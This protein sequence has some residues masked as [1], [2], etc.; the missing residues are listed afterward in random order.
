MCFLKSGYAACFRASL[1]N[2]IKRFSSE[3]ALAVLQT[4]TFTDDRLGLVAEWVR[5]NASQHSLKHCC[6]TGFRRDEWLVQQSDVV[7]LCHC[8]RCGYNRR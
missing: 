2:E 8:R 3:D 1:V 4:E 7:F 6:A 5:R